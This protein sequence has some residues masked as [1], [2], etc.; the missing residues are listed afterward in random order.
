[1]DGTLEHVAAGR[2]ISFLTRS[3]T[4]FYTHPEVTYVRV[5]DLGPDKVCLAV[6]TLQ[7]SPVVDDFITAAQAVA[8]STAEYGNYDMWQLGCD[9]IAS[10]R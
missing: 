1:M 3:A 6:A 5:P 4:V 7:L 9:A 2:G 8:K 10:G